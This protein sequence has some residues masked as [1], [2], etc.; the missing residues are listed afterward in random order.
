VLAALMTAATALF[1][2]GVSIERGQ[3]DEHGGERGEESLEIR[4]S[5]ERADEEPRILGIDPESTPLVVLATVGSLSLA[6]AGISGLRYGPLSSI[7]DE[8]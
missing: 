2:I 6:A 7:V 4:E 3:P 8:R 5:G 1:V